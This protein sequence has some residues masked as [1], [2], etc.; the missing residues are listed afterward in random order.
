MARLCPWI[1]SV[2]ALAAALLAPAVT[3]AATTDAVQRGLRQLVAA[4]GGPP[5][6]VATLYRDG[7]LTVLRAGRADVRHR[8]A[9]TATQH[10][11]IA[12]VAKAFSGAV[13]L[14]LV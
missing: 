4:K 1:P 14:H 12:S 13:A 5:G 6:A 9:P 3:S 11:R 2:V 7:Q 10:M 8:R